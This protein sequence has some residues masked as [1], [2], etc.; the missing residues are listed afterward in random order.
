MI[1]GKFSIRIEFPVDLINDIDESIKNQK[2]MRT[3][4]IIQMLTIGHTVYKNKDNVNNPD[5][6]NAIIENI[7]SDKIDIFFEN[8]DAKQLEAMYVF[9]KSEMEKRYGKSRLDKFV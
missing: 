3:K 6:I 7:V 2:G 4:F 9:A 8:M 1:K 5:F